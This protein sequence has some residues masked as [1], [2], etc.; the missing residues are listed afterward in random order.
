MLRDAG[1]KRANSLA[2]P[3]VIETTQEA[4][5][6]LHLP[7]ECGG[8]AYFSTTRLV[9]IAFS[10]LASAA[11]GYAVCGGTDPAAA[12][13]AK[14]LRRHPAAHGS[15]V[16]LVSVSPSATSSP[17]GTRDDAHLEPSQSGFLKH[18]LD[19][20]AAEEIAGK[21]FDGERNLWAALLKG[22]CRT[23]WKTV[24]QNQLANWKV[25]GITK[26]SLDRY[27]LRNSIRISIV[28]GEMR[29]GYWYFKRNSRSRITCALWLLHLTILRAQAYG[30]TIPDVEMVFQGTDG[31]QSTVLEEFLWDGAGPL[32][33]NVKCKQDASISFPMG[34][35]DQFG[36]FYG[37][38]SLTMYDKKFNVLK[39]QY[40]PPAWKEKESKILFTSGKSPGAGLRGHRIELSEITSPLLKVEDRD[41]PLEEYAKHRYQV[42]AYGRCGWSRR[43]R[44]LSFMKAV[45]FAEAS[46]CREYF[47]DAL[48]PGIDFVPVAENFS[49]L[50][51]ELAR[52]HEHP[53]KAEDMANQWIERASDF[54][55]LPCVLDYVW[56]LLNGYARL[57]RFKPQ[58]RPTWEKY[59]LREE[60]KEETARYQSFLKR[61]RTQLDPNQCKGKRHFGNILT[62]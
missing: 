33:S 5:A 2:R 25:T 57:Q 26:A 17:H 12:A 40:R 48:R 36:A 28:N 18:T 38:M 8:A 10:F 34:F 7:E 60:T 4:A 27:C 50:A 32:F 22:K 56:E 45:V 52:V 37:D 35:H 13:S 29:G 61:N 46:P 39:D 49:N 9:L 14:T 55:A 3:A 54:F 53:T 1:P 59:D 11:L 62:C 51:E 31:A 30:L 23:D 47:Y 20:V 21:F 58:P 15:P 44:E 42:Y 43:I 6:E 19:A 41:V 16:S 24:V